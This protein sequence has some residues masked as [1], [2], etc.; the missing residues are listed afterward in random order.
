MKKNKCLKFVVYQYENL[1]GTNNNISQENLSHKSHHKYNKNERETH[2]NIRN[3][4]ANSSI[5]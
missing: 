2:Y 5:K 1:Q 4:S 3:N